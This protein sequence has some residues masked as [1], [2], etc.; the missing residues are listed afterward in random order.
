MTDKNNSQLFTDAYSEL[1]W[2]IRTH[3]AIILSLDLVATMPEIVSVITGTYQVRRKFVPTAAP[4]R[5]AE[6]AREVQECAQEERL[7]DF[8]TVRKS[9]LVS[10]CSAL[11]HLFKAFFVEW[12]EFDQSKVDA[13]LSRQVRISGQEY[14]S[15]EPRDRLFILADK[16]Y[17]DMPG[18]SQL[19]RMTAYVKEM[20]PHT[21]DEF[22]QSV[23]KLNARNFNEAFAVRNCLV[24]HGARVNQLLSKFPN[25]ELGES[26]KL[27]PEMIGRYF[28]A[29][30]AVSD[31]LS[32]VQ[33]EQLL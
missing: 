2:I 24:H 28:A 33:S 31:A 26:I 19:D 4:G 8:E 18:K 14:L 22:I 25:F 23:A 16:I 10:G 27:T 15:Q 3:T 1:R 21:S 9:A 5:A 30:F 12:A 7:S 29:L 17:Q 6:I 32:T 13:A 20:V 11:E